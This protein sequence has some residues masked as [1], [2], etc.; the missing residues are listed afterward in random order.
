[1]LYPERDLL[2][3]FAAISCVRSEG[4]FFARLLTLTRRVPPKQSPT[5]RLQ[6]IASP[7]ELVARHEAICRCAFTKCA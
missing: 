1:M 3:L 5:R 4:G 7:P 6:E 2:A